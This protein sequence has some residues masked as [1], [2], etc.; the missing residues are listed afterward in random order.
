MEGGSENR[1]ASERVSSPATSDGGP[2]DRHDHQVPHNG[3]DVIVSPSADALL[4]TASIAENV[5]TVDR[6]T[7]ESGALAVRA[8]PLDVAVENSNASAMGSSPSHSYREPPKSGDDVKPK[9][10]IKLRLGSNPK[11]AQDSKTDHSTDSAVGGIQPLDDS[12]SKPRETEESASNSTSFEVRKEGTCSSILHQVPSLHFCSNHL[13][14]T[15]YFCANRG[16]SVRI[17]PMATRKL[18]RTKKNWLLPFLMSWMNQT[19]PHRIAAPGTRRI[20]VMIPLFH[21]Q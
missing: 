18:K 7:M 10:R 4:P 3:R 1:D 17:L 5:I 9:I 2:S 13:S 14:L 15:N 12:T 21:Q 16:R 11:N 8:D 19:T 20:S 6:G